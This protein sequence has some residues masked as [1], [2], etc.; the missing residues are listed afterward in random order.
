MDRIGVMIN[1]DWVVWSLSLE[2]GRAHT[3]MVKI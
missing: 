3:L 2:K 1:C